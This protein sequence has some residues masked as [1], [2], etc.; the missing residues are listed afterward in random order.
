MTTFDPERDGWWDLRTA[1]MRDS[2][3]W[4]PQFLATIRRDAEELQVLGAVFQMPDWW[5]QELAP[6]TSAPHR[7]GRSPRELASALQVNLAVAEGKFRDDLYEGQ[8][9]ACGRPGSSLANYKKAPPWAV[10]GIE[11]WWKG[12]GI[13]RIESGEMLYAARVKP[14]TT[15]TTNGN[16]LPKR[17]RNEK[18]F[19]DLVKRQTLG[20]LSQ[21]SGALQQVEI[22]RFIESTVLDLEQDLSERACRDWAKEFIAAH[23]GQ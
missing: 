22:E 23:E 4:W 11:S 3:A 2:A 14:T 18:P 13:L 16:P 8:R 20:W 6:A 17:G 1:I 10:V 15:T 12:G 21:Q 7:A 5:L 9:T 19:K